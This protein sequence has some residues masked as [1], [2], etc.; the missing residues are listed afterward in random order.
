MGTLTQDLRLAF[1]RLRQSPGFTAAAILTLA[2]GIGANTVVF[3]ALNT[4]VLRPLP[5]NR[6]GELVFLNSGRGPSQSYLNFLDFRDRNRSLTGLMA[7]RIAQVAMNQA[8]GANAHVWG[9]EASGQYFDVLGVPALLGRTLSPADDQKRG[10]SPVVVISYSSWQRR[11]GGDPAIVGKNVKINGL[12]YA[13]VGVMPRGFFGTELIFA[14]EFWAPLSM[15]LQIEPDDHWLDERMASN[16]WVVGRLK[17]GISNAQAQADLNSVASQIAR[18]HPEM[19]GLRVVL[20]APGLL[21]NALR[22]AVSGFAVVLMGVAGLVLLIACTNLASLLLSRASERRKEIAIRLALGAGQGRLVRQLLTESLLLSLAGGAAGLAL[23]VWLTGLLGAWRPPVDLPMNG[24]FAIDARVL[25]FTAAI[26][27]SATMLFGLIPAL[28]AA[29]AQLIGALKN[30]SITER[31]RGF[32]VRDVMVAAQITLSVVLITAS[33]L[34]VRSLQNALTI[35]FGFNPRNAVAVAFDLSLEGY[36]PAH[37]REFQ[38][39]LLERVSA[40][41]GIESA[42]LANSLPLGLDQNSNMVVAEGKPEPPPS[43]RASIQYYQVGPGYFR[44]MQTRLIAGRAL[45][46]RDRLGATAVA[47][48]N[49]AFAARLFPGEN[50]LGKRFRWSR[51]WTQIVGIAE[52][53][54]YIS[55]SD[56]PT[57]VTFLPLFQSYNSSTTVVARSSL[58]P[59]D[60]VR[61]IEKTVHDMDSTIPFYE[62]ASLDDHM[63]IPLLPARIAAMLLSGFGVL[64]IVLAAVGVYGVM[65]YAVSRRTREIGIRM[66]IGATRGVADDDRRRTGSR[67]GICRGQL[68][69]AD[70]IWRQP[71]GSGGVRGGDSFHGRDRNRV[72]LDSG[73]AGH[74]GG[75]GV[76]AADGVNGQTHQG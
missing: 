70:P 10:A 33:A 16:A 69:P 47:V 20:S 65:A 7:Y 11:F 74:G 46:E 58:P 64:A 40:L 73:A 32:Q 51:D 26:S 5:V 25:A 61:A 21:G 24:A 29:R 38:R 36:D 59:A 62:A 43:Q 9:Y 34:V 18:E 68:I 35:N 44:T 27:V 53:G 3:S 17:P 19:Q 42:S 48:V 30:E 76:G 22:G 56:G 1:R 54:K 55:L 41:P 12:S 23:A 45:D 75:S 39:R 4:F 67:A 50:A 2:L 13:I 49:Q 31:L 63:R 14:P 72:V 60:V 71:K 28:Q 15:E 37:G 8:G 66:A 57:P 52:D 6:P